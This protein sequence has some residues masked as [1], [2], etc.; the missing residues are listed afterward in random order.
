MSEPTGYFLEMPNSQPSN[1]NAVKIDAETKETI[2]LKIV[3]WQRT[4]AERIK[5]KIDSHALAGADDGFRSHLG[6]SVIGHECLRY[7]YYHWRWF[8]KEE[9]HARMERIFIAG[10][11]IEAELRHILTACGATFLDTVDKDGKQLKVSDLGGHFGG[12]VDGVFIWPEIGLYE[13]TLLECKSSKTG[14]PFNDLVKNGVMKS[15]PRHY[16]QQSGYGKGLDIKFACY[17]TRNKN[18]SDI[19]VEIVDLD[20]TLAEE[21]RK[22]AQFIILET[23]PP[24]RISE[25]RNFYVCNMCAMQ[26]LCHD[27][28]QPVPNCRNCENASPGPEATWF[29]KH[30]NQTI[31]K[32]A[33]INGCPQHKFLPY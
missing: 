4:I 12:S 2:D 23:T 28:L 29:C 9:H 7:L 3:H 10:H 5:L 11:Q 18:D 25:K 27:R 24:K 15:K 26:K 30:W 31:P 22:K 32:E 19:F 21:M 17:V 20:F 8:W 13:P 1:A 33:I 16:S 6:W 14:S